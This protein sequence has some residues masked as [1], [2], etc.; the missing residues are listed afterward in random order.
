MESGL[1]ASKA[2]AITPYYLWPYLFWGAYLAMVRGDPWLCTE[3]LPLAVLSICSWLYA[4]KLLLLVL[5]GPSGI[6]EIEL[7]LTA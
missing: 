1:T 2:N 7:G 4:H 3:A 6:L 5:R